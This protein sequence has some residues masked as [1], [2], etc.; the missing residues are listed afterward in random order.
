MNDTQRRFKIGQALEG[1]EQCDYAEYRLAVCLLMGERPRNIS[2]NRTI[3]DRVISAWHA[4]KKEFMRDHVL[5]P[6]KPV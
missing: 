1:L 6:V 5:I 2:V 4:A 3:L